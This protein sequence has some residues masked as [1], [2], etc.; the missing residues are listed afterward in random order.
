MKREIKK[1]I[2]WLDR[3]GLLVTAITATIAFTW[4]G[5]TILKAGGG[6]VWKLQNVEDKLK[7]LQN[8]TETKEEA[9]EL[10]EKINQIERSVTN[11]TLHFEKRL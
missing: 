11:F 10:K 1:I 8:K 7:E 4:M 3:K 9:K 2:E 5:F 6:W